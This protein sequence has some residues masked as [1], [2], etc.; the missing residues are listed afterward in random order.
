VAL[1]AVFLLM[2]L[3]V[4][5]LM[6]LV[7]SW[8]P[9]SE[10]SL[11]FDSA[12]AIFFIA[13]YPVSGSALS[14]LQAIVFG[15]ILIL[16]GGILLAIQRSG[17][18]PGLG[19]AGTVFMAVLTAIT[20]GGMIVLG[21]YLGGQGNLTDPAQ[22][23][24]ILPVPVGLMVV[25][26]SLLAQWHSIMIG[27]IL[28][29]AAALFY[30]EGPSLMRTFKN[31][32]QAG[33]L[34]PLRTDN[35]IITIFRMY[36]AILG[37][38]LVYTAFLLA[39]TVEPEVPAFDELPLWE[40]LHSF[41]EA[42]VW[43]EI[44]SRVFMLGIPMLIYHIWTRQKVEGTWRYVVG[45]G[46][47]IDTAAFVLIMFQ[48]MVFALAHVSGWDLWKVL[49]TLI[50]GIAFGYL[51]LKKGLWASIILHFT[52]DYLGMTAEVMGEWGIVADDGINLA[53]GMLA[54][55]GLV[56]M[57]HYVVIVI[58]EGPRHLRE[59]LTEQPESARTGSDG[60]A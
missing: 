59:A 26:F 17:R 22:V 21:I 32:I 37:F 25:R 23:S 5:D 49:P 29:S 53:Y 14:G 41:A 39:F 57:V 44:L 13:P 27:G 10:A 33:V 24:N 12:S 9:V 45:G 35:A 18:L 50:S 51:Y 46:F 55:V 4:I 47:S 30:L 2:A 43:E 54:V 48:A 16:I 19:G 7:W 20:G 34:P 11:R 38:Y 8:W 56:L 15:A 40:Q 28:M 3:V 6:A 36:L 31:S 42:S 52:F 58:K 60:K 1:F